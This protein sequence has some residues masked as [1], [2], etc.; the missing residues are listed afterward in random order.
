MRR[1]A[2]WKIQLRLMLM[3]VRLR[4]CFASHDVSS[5][6]ACCLQVCLLKQLER[7]L[8]LT[9]L[10]VNAF[11]APCYLWWKLLLQLQLWLLPQLLPRQGC[12]PSGAGHQLDFEGLCAV[13]LE[14]AF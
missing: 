5:W 2:W 4:V 9:L 8:V 13:R 7:Q 12:P 11:A 10:H 1:W 6:Q 3:V 14:E